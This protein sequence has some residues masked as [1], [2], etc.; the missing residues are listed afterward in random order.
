M[1]KDLF[2]LFAVMSGLLTVSGCGGGGGGGV[3]G[4]GLPTPDNVLSAE[5]QNGST[6]GIEDYLV[7]GSGTWQVNLDGQVRTIGYGTA[8]LADALIYDPDLDQWTINI[9]GADF[10]LPY[11]DFDQNYQTASCMI[12]DCTYFYPFD[13]DDN[14]PGTSQY[15]MLGYVFHQDTEKLVD[16]FGHVGLKTAPANM[17]G[18]TGV[19]AGQ[20][21]GLVNYSE[22]TVLGPFDYLDGSADITANFTGGTIAFASSG[23]G[24]GSGTYELTGDA[25][26][27]GNT[28]QGTVTGWYH[29]GVSI[30]LQLDA[31]G[32]GSSLSGAFYGPDADETAGVV[33]ATSATGDPNWG[34]FAGGFWAGQSPP[35]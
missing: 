2:Q 28:Y 21:H 32:A 11:D 16:F 23:T 31:D 13:N 25:T 34:E 20:F 5:A 6:K 19:Y 1:R 15:G 30:S 7:R 12:G 14:D 18:G 9:D 22:D 10:V 17:P 3:A 4:A 24:L 27:S 35:P 29:D 8:T 26:I 33:Y